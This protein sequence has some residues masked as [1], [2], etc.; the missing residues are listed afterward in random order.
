MLGFWPES[1]ILWLPSDTEV[2]T[3]FVV[4]AAPTHGRGDMLIIGLNPGE[5]PGKMT[6]LVLEGDLGWPISN[7]NVAARNLKTGDMRSVKTT[8]DGTFLFN[9][10]VEGKYEVKAEAESRM[11]EYRSAT[12]E[13]AVQPNVIF[14]LEMERR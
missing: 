7:V 8:S 14:H 6:G 10:L 11:P 1:R 4:R 5:P 12:V 9:H 2:A 13:Y 3:D